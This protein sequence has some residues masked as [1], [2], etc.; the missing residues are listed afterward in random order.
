MFDKSC[1]TCSRSGRVIC[2]NCKGGGRLKWFLQ[3]AVKFV[4]N[5]EDYFKKSEI[6]PDDLL[7]KCL[8]KNTFSEQ[9]SRVCLLIN[10]S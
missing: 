8:A 10:L 3:L 5:K 7:R 2:N 6:I 1:L 9:N 4:N